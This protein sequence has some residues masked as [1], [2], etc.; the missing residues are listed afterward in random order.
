[1]AFVGGPAD[2]FSKPVMFPSSFAVV[3]FCSAGR[4]FFFIIFFFPFL[5]IFFLVFRSAGRFFCFVFSPKLHTRVTVYKLAVIL[6][7]GGG[8]GGGLVER[9]NVLREGIVWKS[10]LPP[11]LQW[12][13]V[14][15][16]GKEHVIR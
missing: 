2:E 13:C 12:R 16:G 3:V 8:G 11:P 4:F 6:T 7:G 15:G 10:P 1:M 5:N 9:M 14:W